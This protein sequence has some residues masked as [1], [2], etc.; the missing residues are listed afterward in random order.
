[1]WK[2]L[3]ISMLVLVSSITVCYAYYNFKI[4][5]SPITAA[6]YAVGDKFERTNTD[7]FT[8]GELQWKII[9]TD[10][11][12][13]KAYLVSEP[14]T[15]KYCGA[16]NL[17]QGSVLSCLAATDTQ[18]TSSTVND[19][20]GDYVE[21]IN[22]KGSL[23]MM[24]LDFYNKVTSNNTDLGML[25]AIGHFWMNEY[26]G[27]I[28]VAY[29]SGNTSFV[30]YQF[31]GVTYNN[32]IVLNSTST[33]IVAVKEIDLPQKGIIKTITSDATDITKPSADLINNAGQ[34]IVNI[35]TTE[36]EGP[37]H[38]YVYDTNASGSGTYTTPSQYFTLNS[39]PS[40]GTAQ[41]NLLNKLPAG[42]Y[43]FKVRVVD[44][45]TNERLYYRPDD[46]IKD[47]FRTKETQLIHVKIYKETPTIAFDTPSITKKS[48]SNAGAGWNET[49]AASPST[50]TKITYSISGGDVSLIS[51]DP[52]TGAITYN[53]NN[54]F[55]KVKIKATVD[56]DPST[57]YDDYEAA[58]AEKEIII[59]REL[60]GSV[61]PH[62]NSSDTTVPTFTASDSNIKTGGIIGTIH[63]TLGTPD[64]I[65][66]STT[67]Y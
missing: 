12:A 13:H 32:I 19:P 59:Y 11:A 16:F 21:A 15:S 42:D 4:N 33:T 60:D 20:M 41:V 34:T 9:K 17:Y 22:G 37:Y 51:I 66:G 61:T 25:D 35:D 57:G 2:K 38:F 29:L 39:N 40:N 30:P 26:S 46:F 18:Y 67:T 28:Q 44:E 8:M 62:A 6:D 55:G 5:A 63:G 36:G 43:Y 53:G 52:D 1:M 10:S 7:T 45:S 47:T 3:W 58:Y 14:F 31:A 27:S 50:G 23:E 65:G 49:A 48:I 56:D 24:N 64:T 54:A